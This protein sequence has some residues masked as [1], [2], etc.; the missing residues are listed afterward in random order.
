MPLLFFVSTEP[1]TIVSKIRKRSSPQV[2]MKNLM[3][4]ITLT[5]AAAYMSSLKELF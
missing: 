5:E 3:V 1:S 4:C 2:N